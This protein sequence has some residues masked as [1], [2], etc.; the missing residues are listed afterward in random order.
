[1]FS[2][3]VSEIHINDIDPCIYAFWRAILQQTDRFLETVDK[4]PVSVRVWK[5]Q[6]SVLR[7][8]HNHS[9][10]EVGFA[11]FFVNRCNRSG[12][13]NGGPIGGLGQEGN[14]KIDVRFNKD[15]LKRK[16]GK[17]ALYKERITAWNLDGVAF[18]TKIFG[19]CRV[20]KDN[21]LVYMDPPLFREGGKAL[22]LLLHSS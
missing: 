1:M 16:I 3:G 17:I 15:R 9:T 20:R 8:R 4:T 11:T 21:C 14:Y 22:L 6:K 19:A 13:L 2:E 5:Q 18:L 10:F 12:V 7:N